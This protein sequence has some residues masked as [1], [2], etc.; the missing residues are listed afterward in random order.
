VPEAGIVLGI[1]AVSI[2]VGSVV[3]RYHYAADAIAGAVVALLAFL[4]ASVLPAP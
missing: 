4:T 3:G 2:A 1:V